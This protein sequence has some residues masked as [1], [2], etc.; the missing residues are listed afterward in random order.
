[1]VDQAED[2][3]LSKLNYQ[4]ETR[5]EKTSIPGKYEIPRVVISEAIVNAVAH[6]DYTNN[7]SVQVMLFKDR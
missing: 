7:G 5:S 4:V 1:M 3:I 6:R 2:F